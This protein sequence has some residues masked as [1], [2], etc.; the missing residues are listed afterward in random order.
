M[1]THATLIRLCCGAAVFGAALILLAAPTLVAQG[2]QQA[3]GAAPPGQVET[4]PGTPS[5]AENPQ[6]GPLLHRVNPEY[7]KEAKRKH[8]QGDVRIRVVIDKKGRVTKT[9]VESGNRLLAKAAIEAVRKW[10]YEP[11]LV[12]GAPVPSETEVEF[13][14]HRH[15]WRVD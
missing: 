15:K 7:S 12:N 8:L 11:P 4:A 14:F 13:H 10:R 1:K 6:P 2:A 3:A 9:H 5:A